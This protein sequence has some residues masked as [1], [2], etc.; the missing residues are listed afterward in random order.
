MWREKVASIEADK[1]EIAAPLEIYRAG[2]AT[3]NAEKLISIWDRD[4]EQIIYCPIEL[5]QPVRGWPEIE[6]YYRGVTKHFKHVRSMEIDN[7]SIDI[8][9][10]AAY[11]FFTFRFE[12]EVRDKSEPFKVQGRNTLIFRRTKGAWKGIHYH[13]S[14]TGPY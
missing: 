7:L 4:Y 5:A 6:R 2:F 10:D 9:G 1:K 3:L 12:G 14:Q 8:L 13:E 11:A